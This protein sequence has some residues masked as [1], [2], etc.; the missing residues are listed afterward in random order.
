MTQL[1]EGRIP[2][3]TEC[4]FRSQCAFAQQ[5][6]ITC[7]HKGTEH[8]VAFSCGA[9]RGFELINKRQSDKQK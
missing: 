5:E 7:R 1:V 2:A 8:N 6:P 3:N 9:A 4:P